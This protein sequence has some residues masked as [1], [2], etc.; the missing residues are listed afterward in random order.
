MRNVSII[1]FTRS[2]SKQR[3]EVS[4]SVQVALQLSF[5]KEY[6]IE[7]HSY[8]KTT[9]PGWEVGWVGSWVVEL[10]SAKLDWAELCNKA[11]LTLHLQATSVQQVETL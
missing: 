11:N 3:I 8:Y 4:R 10:I 7:S 5:T 2:Y 6:S 1:V 9:I